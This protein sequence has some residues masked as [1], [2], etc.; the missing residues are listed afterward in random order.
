MTQPAQGAPAPGALRAAPAPPPGPGLSVAE[1][2]ALTAAGRANV[3]SSRRRSDGDVVRANAL[4]FFNVVLAS[5]IL[6]LVAVGEFRDGFFVG[7]V[8]AANVALATVQ[9]LAATRRLRDLRALTAPR[10]SV[11]RDGLERSIAAV[12]V[13]EG[14]LLHLNPGDQVVA[15]GA[16]IAGSAQLDEALLSGESEP[17]Q[18]DPG[19]ELQSGSLCVAGDCYYLAERVGDAAYMVQLTAQARELVAR[20]TPLMVR[21]RRLLRV[22]LIL[23]AVLAAALFI[24]FNVQDRGFGESLKAATA[25]VTTVVPV[26]L[27]LAM[28]V[29]TAVGALRVSRSGAIVQSLNAVEALNYVD[30]VGLDKTG[31]LTTNRLTLDAVRWT[32]GAERYAPWLGALA[33]ATADESQTAAAL[34]AALRDTTNGAVAVDSVPFSSARRWS[35]VTLEA[36]GERI[37]L[38]LGAPETILRAA[39]ATG[40]ANEVAAELRGAYE[41]ATA[42]GLRGLALARAP[43]LPRTDAPLR[44]LEPL[45]LIALGDELRGEVAEAFAMMASLE[46]EPKIISGDH[47]QTVSSLLVQLGIETKGGAISGPELDELSG[48]AFDEA[49][50]AHSVF[51][52]IAP[53]QKERI[54]EALK[55]RGHFVAMVGDG[56]NDVR[57]L[58]EADVAVAMASGTATTRSVAG[59]V[60][61]EDSFAAL[62]RGTREAT[63]VLGNT[64]RLSKLF[65]TK[66]VYAFLLILATNMLGL[67]FP[68]LPRQG[69]I[70][71]FLTLGIPAV[72]ISIGV[73]PRLPD[74][75]FTGSVLRFALPAGF[76][77]AIST[78]GLQ[79]L[80]EGLFDRPI[81]EARTL[82]SM[83]IVI[84]GV[85]YVMEVLG[86][87]G[88]RWQ[89]PTRPLLS[90]A[91]AAL[92][93]G[94]LVFTIRTEWLRD[95][96]EFT[97]VSALGWSVV[98]IAVA[99]ALA[100]QFVFTRYW[101]EILDFV[102][103]N[104][105]AEDLPRGRG[106]GTQDPL[107]HRH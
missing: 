35:A 30:V 7:A 103:A 61:L 79:F 73:P 32:P 43:G 24:Q 64:A 41:Q 33:V 9:E 11:V 17:V 65:V 4:T 23:T 26:G 105:R 77:L 83:T 39:T 8:V 51:G 56:V 14:D 91:L 107:E 67:D 88:V 25:T 60:L 101:H 92:L 18:R 81:E 16:V 12:E 5:L 86:L 94:I 52:R 95:F 96:F 3:D 59:I 84:A 69:S 66:S 68:F 87:E 76:A 50:A 19:A 2:A 70:S 47:P 74:L 27:L 36:G 106:A 75:D 44:D 104:P 85:A 72:F 15:D 54:V 46:I 22:L 1:A 89:N 102:I 13:V 21:F 63:F 6:A 100:G 62:I 82:V 29:V 78:I 45:A 90:L 99:V 71:S 31:T 57:A 28:T 40:A 20:A 10:A 38:V 49:V 97:E 34:A 42:R 98:V 58:R 53:A 93:I 55:G 37:V 48:E 80:V